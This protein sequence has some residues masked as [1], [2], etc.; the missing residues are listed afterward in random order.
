MV[1]D[2]TPREEQRGTRAIF[3]WASVVGVAAGIGLLVWFFVPGFRSSSLPNQA[4]N[5]SRSNQTEGASVA[6]H[7]TKPLPGTA[8][9]PRG[10]DGSTAGRNEQLIGS[11]TAKLNLSPDQVHAIKSYVAQHADQRVDSVSFTMTVGAA[12]PRD[13]PLHDMPPPLGQHLQSFSGDQY[14]IVRNQFIVVEKNTRRI[15]AIVPVST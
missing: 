11:A 7:M 9:T 6:A 2:M 5:G 15:V 14:L 3:V 1:K 12:V 8:P 4:A 10:T 13:A